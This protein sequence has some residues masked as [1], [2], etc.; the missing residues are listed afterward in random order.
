MG[1]EQAGR[2][3]VELWGGVECTVNRVGDGYFDQLE[4]NGHARRIEDLDLFAALGV[5]ALRYPL[6]WERIAP[7]GL[8]NVD[9]SWADARLARLREL[10]I[11]PIVGLVHHGSGPRA[12]S[13]LD[14]RFPEKLAAYA[15][16]VATRYPDIDAYT[17]VNEPL[18]TA[19]FSALYGFWY[20]HAR[21]VLSFA[22]ALFTQCRAVVLSMRAIREVNPSARLV[23]TDDLGKTY[24]TPR[25]KYQADWEN[26]RR[27]LSFDLLAGRLTR[28]HA[29]WQFFVAAGVD[30]AELAW[31][32]DN[33]CPPDI[34]GINHY[35]TSERFLDE[36]LE[37]YP[38]ATH[39]GNGR[40]AY[41]DTEAVRVRAE[42]IAGV[43][44]RLPEAWERYGLP[45][46]V[47]EVHLGCTRE[48]QLRWFKEVWDAAHELRRTRGIDVRAVTAWSLLGAFNW[49]TLL[50]RDDGHYEPGVFD[51]RGQPDQPRPTAL[52]HMLGQLARG[53]AYAHPVIEG[54]GW[55][56]RLERLTYPS[57]GR[58]RRLAR[59]SGGASVDAVRTVNMRKDS[60]RPLLI[61]G[62][63][64]TLGRAFARACELRGITYRLL[65]RREMDIADYESVRQA[66]AGYEPWAVVNTAGYV[67][68]DDAEREAE[69]C[70]RENVDGAV[71][72]ASA[73]AQTAT[74]LITFSSD[75]V[76][77]GKLRRPYV[78]SDTV[79]P[80][81]VYGRS[82]ADAERRVLEVHPS[83]LVARTS[84]FF[85]PHDDYNFVTVAL[86]TLASGERFTAA[87]DAH[88]SP[89]Y[90]PDLVNAS[91]D[92]LI[93]GEHGIWHL[94]SSGGA[95]S[96]ADL[97]RRVASL[98][99]FSQ[100]SIDARPTHELG[101]AAA[102][103]AYS[104]L[105]SERG[106]LLP[107]L[108]D[109]LARYIRDCETKWQDNSTNIQ[110]RAV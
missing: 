45:L 2:G 108:D 20:P 21:D 53:D 33:P 65:T 32:F 59:A 47:T 96:W 14:P 43:R 100:Q 66:L 49:N 34:I 107:T 99:G 94:A 103:P 79:A 83:A 54:P 88:I 13:L 61:T 9:W 40:H 7:D 8:E 46:A 48:E 98:A 110:P 37:R 64:G 18:T 58:R 30:E 5:R 3:Q 57:V 27:W 50:T 90:V 70:Y 19:R 52:A 38:P 73:C 109:A 105:G 106:A 74:A 86:R 36:R 82:K 69:V 62:A 12:T 91:L 1:I 60:T 41:A 72:L 22:R 35:L 51:L 42:G 26:E 84:A 81:N 15:R 95:I 11:R 29:M 92:L 31:F 104:V 63:T 4:R 71:L 77:D 28:E 44:G 97:A 78:E 76:F 10:D 75:L 80:L 25:L 101:L 102:R 17:P 67:R 23:Q 68:V 93:D 24:S 16:A 55:W 85:S 39:G 87:D 56:Q 6:L 89:T